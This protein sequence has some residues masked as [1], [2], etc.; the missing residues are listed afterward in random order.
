MPCIF[1][2]AQNISGNAVFYG[3]PPL[4]FPIIEQGDFVFATRATRAGARRFAAWRNRPEADASPPPA[5]RAFTTA[6]P[7]IG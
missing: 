7:E 4:I 5:R 2:A 6:T 1:K 3:I